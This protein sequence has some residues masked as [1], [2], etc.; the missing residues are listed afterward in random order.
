VLALRAAGAPLPPATIGWL[1]RQQ[2][3]DGGFDFGTAGGA[4]D[5][6]DTAS[7]L[8]A[9]AVAGAPR[10]AS[11]RAVAFIRAHQDRDGGF[12]SGGDA[13]SNA[14]STA[15]AIQGL[16]AAGLNPASV[17][18]PGG[19]TP[20]QYL[21]SLIAADGHVR[22]SRESDQTPVWVT[23]EAAMALTGKPLPLTPLAPA[24]RHGAT[25]RAAPRRLAHRTRRAH[26]VSPRP[27]SRHIA[28]RQQPSQQAAAPTTALPADTAVAT[29]VLLAPLGIG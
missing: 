26:P 2:N 22:Y 16:I 19:A 6:D 18:T 23:A 25:S 24:G 28:R 8:E 11:G 20:L 12:P 4:S 14:Q 10:S 13:G 9:L 3:R 29:A 17:H 27:S 1:L 15:W 7:A 21:S 5:V